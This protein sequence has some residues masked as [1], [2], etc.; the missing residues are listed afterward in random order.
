[1]LDEIFQD[2]A[3]PPSVQSP[4]RGRL[5]F[6]R[7]KNKINLTGGDDDGPNTKIKEKQIFFSFYFFL[8]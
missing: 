1:M 7:R 4:S 8:T 5:G 2:G 6:E 3:A